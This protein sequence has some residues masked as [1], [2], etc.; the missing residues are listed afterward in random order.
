MPFSD[1]YALLKR[2][3]GQ[4]GG[5]GGAGGGV[6]SGGTPPYAPP[7][8]GDPGVDPS[9]GGGLGELD[10]ALL[11]AARQQGLLSFG[12]S[13]LQA[14]GSRPGPRIGLGEALG[15][16]IQAGQAGYQGGINNQLQQLLLKAK[17][18]E[19][20]RG[21]QQVDPAKV[22]EYQ[23]AKANGFEGTYEEFLKLGQGGVGN[24]NPGDYTPESFARFQ[25]SGNPADLVR[26]VAPAQPGVS[27]I[28]GVPTVVQ[29]SRTG[30]ATRLDPLSTLEQTAA[31]EE[32][33]KGAGAEGAEVGKATGAARGA[34][35][36]KGIESVNVLK[37]LDQAEPLLDIATGSGAGAAVDKI[38][39]FFG[40]APS[41][42]QAAAQLKVLGANLVLG[43]PRLE[44]PQSDRD[45]ALYKEAAA[46]LGDPTVPGEIKRAAL[47][48]IR[49][50][51]Q[52]YAEQF[53]SGGAS[54]GVTAPAA[55]VSS[56]VEKYRTKK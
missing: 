26:Y 38:V 39:G 19:A 33:L 1:L 32:T 10:P 5:L 29:G 25:Q 3:Q 46:Q 22:R 13:L 40:Y 11:K 45:T 31:A 14:A 54:G 24:F 35:A 16:A 28:N 49:R 52:E 37:M 9:G 42:A 6:L 27:I 55:N 50:I 20:Q 15:G 36:K 30:G 12:A 48:T 47:I 51:Q 2:G 34:V 44:G 8:G 7:P 17:I 21:P 23:F 53:Q 4:I 56:L 43:L 18:T 41:S